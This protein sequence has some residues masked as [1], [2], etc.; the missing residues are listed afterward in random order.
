MASRDPAFMFYPADYLVGTRLFTY[1]QKGKYVE[2]LCIQHQHG[3][4][5][6]E[7]MISI[8]GGH[9]KRIFGKFKKDAEGQ[10][11][12]KRLEKEIEKRRAY[13]LSRMK[14][15]GIN[16]PSDNFSNGDFA[17]LLNSGELEEIIMRYFKEMKY[18]SSPQAFIN[19][20]S[21]RGWSG[22][23]GEELA[24][25]YQFIDEWEKNER[26]HRGMSLDV[27]PTYENLT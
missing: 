6:R 18:I 7:D 2:L 4:I 27:I 10:Y 9:D 11:Y 20:N 26:L 1:E 8:C 23:M 21:K 12:N 14:N 17:Y 24:V 13:S 22:M 25:L 16:S 19:Y 15:L 5:S 3:H